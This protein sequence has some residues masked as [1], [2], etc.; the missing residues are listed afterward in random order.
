[1]S[2]ILKL[3]LA[4]ALLATILLALRRPSHERDWALDQRLLPTATVRGDVVEI[5]NVRN[6]AYRG[7]HDFEPRYETRTY[8]LRRLDS[9]W[10]MVERFG[11]KPGIAHTLLSFGFG[12]E[13]VAV[14][15]EIRKEK[16]ETYS[17]WR[18]LLRE[19]ELMYV[20]G[21]ER[22]LI[23]L[24]TNHRRD[25]VYLYPMRTT[26]E[27]MRKA[28]LGIVSRA[29]DLA[30][31]PEFYNTLTNTC[32]TNIVRHVN[33]VVPG[34]VPFSFKVLLPAYSDRLAYDLGLI[35]TD[36]PFESARRAYRIDRVAQS[37]GI[38][39]KFSRVIRRR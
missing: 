23:G 18:G 25:E 26:P 32:T 17:P 16:G 9:V 34:R 1:M 4:V 33:D 6:F 24:R 38:D 2:R 8:D 36:Q 19:Y 5:R 12:D 22:D 39:E 31:K 28:F 7:E 29:N 30:T 21:D 14:S 11:T 15:A 3:T 35:A 13:F 37:A 27:N 10:F 20:I